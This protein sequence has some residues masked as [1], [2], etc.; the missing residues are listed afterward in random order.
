MRLLIQRSPKLPLAIRFVLVP[1]SFPF[2][3]LVSLWVVDLLESHFISFI[4]S[5]DLVVVALGVEHMVSN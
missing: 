2:L 5:L 4:I 1:R 3:F